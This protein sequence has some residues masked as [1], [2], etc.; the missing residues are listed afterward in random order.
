MGRRINEIQSR[1]ASELADSAWRKKIL[2]TDAVENLEQHQAINRHTGAIL[3]RNYLAMMDGIRFT[4]PMGELTTSIF[5]EDIKH[6]HGDRYMRA[7][8]SALEQHIEYLD[9]HPKGPSSTSMSRV[10]K[11][12]GGKAESYAHL[13]VEQHIA[14]E[15]QSLKASMRDSSAER[16]R[17]LKLAARRP[18]V[19][20]VMTTVFVR[21]QD[22]V[23]EVLTRA[24]GHCEKC[25]APA[26]FK[27]ASSGQPYL[28]VH[29]RIRLAD[30]GEDTVENAL[31]LCPNCHRASHYG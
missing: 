28:E 29:H 26:P 27:R 24:G 22:V 25:E 19:R 1:A 15:E 31:A 14:Q 17:R 30:G 10:W 16:R 9:T 4:G 11:A 6:R 23:A 7:A 20:Q 2:A 21:N 5:L 12:F 8:L 3:V 18:A 13:T